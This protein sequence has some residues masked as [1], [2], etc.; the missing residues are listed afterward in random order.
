MPVYLWTFDDRIYHFAALVY[1]VGAVLNTF[2]VRSKAWPALLCYAIPNGLAMF[3]VAVM[4]F[5][6]EGFSISSFIALVLAAVITT[7]LVIMVRETVRKVRVSRDTTKALL[8]AQKSETLANFSGGV[9]HDF[10]N[11]LGVILASLEQAKDEKDPKGRQYLLDQAIA[12]VDRGAGLTKQL[13]TVGR[14]TDLKTE[15]INVEQ[16]TTELKQFLSRIIPSSINLHVSH[17]PDLKTIESEP[18]LLQSMLLNLALNARAAMADHGTLDISIDRFESK[19]RRSVTSG[20]LAPG[21]Y[22]AFQVEDNGRGMGEEVFGQ[23]L[24]PFF[25]TRP[26]GE[27]TGLGLAM[28]A[29]FTEQVGGALDISTKE[30][31]G[32]IVRFYL[33]LPKDPAP[34]VEAVVAETNAV[35]ATVATNLKVLLVEDEATLNKMLSRHL[36]LQNYTVLSCENGDSAAKQI[37]AGYQPDVIIT[38]LVMPGDLQGTDLVEYIRAVQPPTAKHSLC[39]NRLS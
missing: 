12:A 13:L 6:K 24:E 4:F 15:T 18:T 8:L 35:E 7:Y 19:F 21:K 30:G 32:T 39:K 11:L 1:T 38:D 5:T 28:V 33:P 17:D 10:N 37:D 20:F 16:F 2:V 29:G 34:K 27:G 22:A 36:T 23:V 14:R 25:S 26:V 3:A 9:A 31:V